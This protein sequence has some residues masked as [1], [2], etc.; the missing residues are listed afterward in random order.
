MTIPDELIT[1]GTVNWHSCAYLEKLFNNLINKAQSPDRL[2][3]VI[4]DNTNG[5]DDLEKLKNVFQNITIIK[6]NPGRLK[7]SP[8]H[9]SGLNIAMKNI[10]TPYALILDPDVYIFKKDWDSFLIDLLNQNDIFTLG[11]SFPPW[12]L[13]MYHNFPN[14]VFCFFRTKPY[15]EFSPNWSA[16]DVNKFVLFWDF[17]R[18]NLLRLGILIGRK[19]FENSEL[20]RILWTRFEKII[21]PCSRDT[22][23]RRAQ[24][25]EKAGTKTIIFQPRIISS[26]EFK[27]D[28]PCS[29][30]AKYFELYCYRNEPMLTHKYSTNSL[31][32]KT[33]KSDNSDLWKQCIEQIEKQR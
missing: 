17:I 8:A 10:K 18:R 12:Q 30:I 13:G 1:I 11:V 23:W 26:K 7:G 19:R 14:P 25:A 9:A 3:F 15:L 20:V 27:P 5:E 16:Y 33:G 6:N 28:D 21:G 31:V 2:C 22:G 29:A 24:K 32:F 4:I